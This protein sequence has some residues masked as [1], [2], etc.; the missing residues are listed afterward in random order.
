MLETWDEQLSALGEEIVMD[1]CEFIDG[2]STIA[3]DL[4]KSIT[5]A[6]RGWR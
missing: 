5:G 3:Y 6:G 1:R 4:H 2:L